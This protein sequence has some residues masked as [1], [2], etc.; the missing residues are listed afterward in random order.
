MFLVW[1]KL[2]LHR[3]SSRGSGAFPHSSKLCYEGVQIKLHS[4]L[5]SERNAPNAPS[6]PSL[7]RR[8]HRHTGHAEAKHKF[9]TPPERV[10]V[11]VISWRR[12]EQRLIQNTGTCFSVDK[13]HTNESEGPSTELDIFSL[14][15]YFLSTSLTPP[16]SLHS[17]YFTNFFYQTTSQYKDW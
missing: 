3:R 12:A 1:L 16:L 4:F 11:H 5:A 6:S 15:H 10:A 17:L 9:L 7:D 14:F 8:S 13:C 2:S